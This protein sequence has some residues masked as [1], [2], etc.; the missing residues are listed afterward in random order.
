MSRPRVGLVGA[1]QRRQGLGP[2]VAR[3]L[4]R[5]GARVPCFVTTSAATRDAASGQLADT[6]GTAVRGYLDVEEMLACER[7]D[8]LAI[9]S[10]AETHA[11]YLEAALAAGLH[12]LCEKPLVWGCPDLAATA[13]RLVDVF[14]R[15]GV[16]LWENCQWPY[17]LRAYERLFPG[18]LRRPPERFSMLMQ[19]ASAGV[20][21][22]GDSLSHPLSLL[23]TLVPGEGPSL[24]DLHF[25]V[26]DPARGEQT[27]AFRYCTDR[28]SVR[29]DVRLTPASAFP[30]EA[31]FA[32][33]G[34]LARRRV[35]SK[36]YRLS[37][38]SDDGQS[39]PLDDPMTLLIADFVGEL[40][41]ARSPAKSRGIAERMAFLGQLV[42][43][44]GRLGREDAVEAGR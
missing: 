2:F 25:A 18:A 36:G 12:V 30:R 43:A 19:P 33:D 40:E 3:D 39:V 16:L 29:V 9:L 17:T 6:C 7:L 4:V 37:F 1:R 10:P 35:E 13:A 20:Q 34:R 11:A 5:A 22:F 28:W 8:A 26:V 23:Q 15:A 32:L 31:A 21:A 42:D 14:D 27:V 38:A 24:V 44:R 41:G